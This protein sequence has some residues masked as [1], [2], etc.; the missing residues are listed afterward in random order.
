MTPTSFQGTRRAR[1]EIKW[2]TRRFSASGA[3]LRLAEALGRWARMNPNWC[4]DVL[5]AVRR[6]A[7]ALAAPDHRVRA[8][9]RRRVDERAG[10]RLGASSLQG[11]H[12]Y[13][14]STFQGSATEWVQRARGAKKVSKILDVSRGGF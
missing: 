1:D 8:A 10:N 2:Q 6:R 5:A 13:K 4:P 12:K 9:L 14:L 3:G 11:V 7:P